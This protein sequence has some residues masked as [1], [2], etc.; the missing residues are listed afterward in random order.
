MAKR[1]GITPHPDMYYKKMFETIPA[2]N[3]KLY[4]AEYKNKIIAADL[5]VFFE[6]TATYLHGASD[7]EFRNVMAPHLLKWQ[8]ILDA[9]EKGCDRFDLGGIKTHNTQHITHSK[10]DWAGIT[11]FKLGFSKNTE[12]TRFLGS[13]DIIVDR[14]K[15]WL[16]KIMQTT[17]IFFR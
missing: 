6:G 7:S 12:P 17:K 8:E 4:L 15:Y 11:R 13:Y 2:D 14:F 5:V 10:N 9:K 1:Q 16:Y 3:L